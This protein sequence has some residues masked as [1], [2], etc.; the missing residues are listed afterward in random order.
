ME[1]IDIFGR[2]FIFS[3]DQSDKYK[4]NFGAVLTVIMFMSFIPLFFVFGSDIYQKNIPQVITSSKVNYY[5]RTKID[6][7]LPFAIGMAGF[8]F[9]TDYNITAT[10]KT[11][12]SN[13]A[14]KIQ[15]NSTKTALYHCEKHNFQDT[16]DK[17]DFLQLNLSKCLNE[18]YPLNGYSN[19][20]KQTWIKF[21]IK[22]C[23]NGT[24]II[25]ASKSEIECT[26]DFLLVFY[27]I[28]EDY[29]LTPQNY[30]FPY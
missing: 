18:T 28:Y 17:F 27:I 24:D 2:N 12:Y 8:A 25:C 6:F 22:E 15:I 19:T 3:F 9:G 5:N 20:P 11:S 13:S 29:E 30:T 4:T 1:R 14:F 10:F 26:Y 21:G 23:Q 16:A 7:S